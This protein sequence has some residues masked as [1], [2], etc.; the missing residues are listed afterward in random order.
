MNQTKRHN[1]KLCLWPDIIL[2]LTSTY[3]VKLSYR[4][5][6]NHPLT[7]GTHET[8]HSRTIATLPQINNYQPQ[9]TNEPL[10]SLL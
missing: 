3:Y 10:A 1:S 4:D 7:D 5:K 2:H 6:Q 9:T 8:I